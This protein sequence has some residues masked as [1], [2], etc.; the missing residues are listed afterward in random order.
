MTPRNSTTAP[1]AC[2]A[3]GGYEKNMR[4]RKRHAA[5]TYPHM[6]ENQKSHDAAEAVAAPVAAGEAGVAQGLQQD[7]PLAAW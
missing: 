2:C 1:H 6:H 3:G 5:T 7:A 4:D